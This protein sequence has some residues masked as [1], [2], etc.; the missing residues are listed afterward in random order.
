[1]QIIS[2]YLLTPNLR[3]I[4]VYIFCKNP[5]GLFLF[6]DGRSR[7]WLKVPGHNSGGRKIVL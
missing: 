7:I 3:H 4:K 6:V 2:F 1:M 5:L